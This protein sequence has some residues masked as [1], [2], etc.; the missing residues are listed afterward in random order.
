MSLYNQYEINYIKNNIDAINNHVK[1]I[2]NKLFKPTFTDKQQIKDIIIKYIQ[3][4]K[5]KIYG[6]YAI[7][8]LI[9]IKN[10]RD[11]IYSHIDIPD[12]DF[13]SP[14]PNTDIINLCNLLHDAGFQHVTGREA[15][16]KYT[17]SIFVEYDLYCDITY[18]PKNIYNKIPFK[19]IN[20]IYYVHPNFINID[21]LKIIT[22]PFSYWRLEKCIDRIDLLH[23]YYPITHITESIYIGETDN[24]ENIKKSINIICD[25]LI[26]KQDI[27]VIGFYAYN[28]FL[29]K[30]GLKKIKFVQIPFIEFISKNFVSDAKT[31]LDILKID[32]DKITHIEFHP[33]FIYFSNRVEIYLDDELICIIYD[34][35]KRCLMYQNVKYID[36]NNS[37]Y[38]EINNKSVNIGT[39]TLT[40]L[41]ANVNILK[42]KINDD[43][44]KQLYISMCSHLIQMKDIFFKINKLNLMDKHIFT[45]FVTDFIG[46]NINPD[47][48]I[49]I[50]YEKRRL[51]NKPSIYIYDPVKNKKDEKQKNFFFP[52]ISG[53]QITNIKYQKL[54]EQHI[55]D[56][57]DNDNEENQDIEFDDNQNQDIVHDDNE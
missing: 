8:E 51:K 47:H 16:H 53:N 4:N 40:L 33:F 7:N 44:L 23:K 20:N 50:K 29:L 42:Y 11:A 46:P 19:I 6:G 56:D 27:I 15:K 13:Y 22:D 3:K 48:E 36:F 43:D 25:F 31:L 52:N 49:L 45:D 30:S 2:T 26:N 32:F 5:R 12:I 35:D 17:Y 54:S 28:Y 38:I 57:S 55:E 24:D 21:Y 18:V 1:T 10:N 9:I 14:D 39:L 37:Q 34:Y 41:F